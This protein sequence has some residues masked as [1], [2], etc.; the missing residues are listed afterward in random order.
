M[1]CSNS[2]PS[3]RNSSCFGISNDVWIWIALI[4]AVIALI[5]LHS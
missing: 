2:F 5:F 1:C 3:L 4:V